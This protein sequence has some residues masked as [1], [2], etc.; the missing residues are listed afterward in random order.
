M[1]QLG[2]AKHENIIELESGAGNHGL[3]IRDRLRIE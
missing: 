3:P 1:T 2:D